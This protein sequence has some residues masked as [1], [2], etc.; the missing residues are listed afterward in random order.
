[1]G[2]AKR[3][4]TRCRFRGEPCCGASGPARQNMRAERC[5]PGRRVAR[6]RWR[7]CAGRPCSSSRRARAIHSRCANRASIRRRLPACLRSDDRACRVCQAQR[8][9]LDPDHA[10]ECQPAA[11]GGA[12]A[13][14]ETWSD[15]R[16]RSTNATAAASPSASMRWIASAS[17]VPSSSASPASLIGAS[18]QG[19]PVDAERGEAGGLRALIS[20]ALPA[21]GARCAG[22]SR[23]GAG[24]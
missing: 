12:A 14:L 1:M 5:L 11:R 13:R 2:Q 10:A 9:G 8:V 18:A 3:T 7:G 24:P 17:G 21:S 4:E 20:A 6:W 22:H 15:A 23:R 19:R 16:S